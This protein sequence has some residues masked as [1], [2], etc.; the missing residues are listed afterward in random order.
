MTLWS[1]N[2]MLLTEKS[3]DYLWTKQTV[4]ANNIANAETPGFKSSYVTFEEELQQNIG[5]L[6]SPK[7]REI[8]EQIRATQYRV[9]RTDDETNKMDESNVD[10]VAENAE[11]SK[12]GIQY[13]YAVR[14]ISD[15]LARLRSAIK[16]A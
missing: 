15:D 12:S 6:H 1:G 10:I 3:L 14:A 11:L 16:G 4:S 13:E 2:T 9:Q 8:R 5:R 7:A